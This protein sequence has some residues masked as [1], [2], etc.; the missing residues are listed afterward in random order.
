MEN[1]IDQRGKVEHPKELT[2]E[3]GAFEEQQQQQQQQ[4]QIIPVIEEEFS[5]SKEITVKEAKIEK[6]FI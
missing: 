3:A 4:E 6:F 2:N 5:I 1:K